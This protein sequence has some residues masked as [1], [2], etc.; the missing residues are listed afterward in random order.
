MKRILIVEDNEL[1]LDLL[2]QLL[3]DEYELITADNGAA[4]VEVAQQE[5][6]DLILMDMSLPVMDG[7]EATRRLKAD[8]NVNHIPVI[9]LTAHAMSSDEEKALATGCDS[10]L[11]KPL[12][13]DLLFDKLDQLLA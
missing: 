10:Y 3:E 5:R 6:P 2:V 11:S 12:D 4:G 13:E 8:S 1:N 7:W 9:A